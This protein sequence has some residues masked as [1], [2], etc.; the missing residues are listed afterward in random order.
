MTCKRTKYCLGIC[1]YTFFLIAF[2]VLLLVLA[3]TINNKTSNISDDYKPTIDNWKINPIK[4]IYVG[5]AT[6]GKCPEGHK[7]IY[8]LE[9]PGTNEGKFCSNT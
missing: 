9:W 6:D 8:N 4:A 7:H 2:Q 5:N 3:F 1:F